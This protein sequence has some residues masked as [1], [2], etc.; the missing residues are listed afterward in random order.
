MT[1]EK[2]VKDLIEDIESL[3]IKILNRR[4]FL[5]EIIDPI[6]KLVSEN[7]VVLKYDKHSCHTHIVSELNNFG[8]FSFHTDLGQTMFGGDTIT[9]YYHPNRKFR[10]GGI[11][12]AHDKESQPVLEVYEQIDYEIKKF[13]EQKNWQRALV[14]VLKNKDRIVSQIKKE[15]KKT[16]TTITQTRTASARNHELR[17]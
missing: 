2:I 8:H 15:Q 12:S 16:K 13:D 11:D 6:I 1:H 14:R 5:K 10:E 17:E 4:R 9:I 7:G 3:T